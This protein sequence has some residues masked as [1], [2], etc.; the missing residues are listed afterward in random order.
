MHSIPIWL[1]GQLGRAEM[2]KLPIHVEIA[3]SLPFSIKHHKL[4]SLWCP[5]PLSFKQNTKSGNWKASLKHEHLWFTSSVTP[6][7]KLK[8]TQIKN[9]LEWLRIPSVIKLQGTYRRLQRT[10]MNKSKYISFKPFIFLSCIVSVLNFI[11][12]QNVTWECYIH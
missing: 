2:Q 7:R 6:T 8:Q 9:E 3:N 4:I 12:K 1:P 11:F 5:I 10:K